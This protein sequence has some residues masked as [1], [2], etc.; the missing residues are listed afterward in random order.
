LADSVI[1]IHLVGI[2]GSQ[3]WIEPA[4]GITDSKLLRSLV[5]PDVDPDNIIYDDQLFNA[6]LVSMGCMG[7][8]YAVVLRVRGAYDLIETTVETTWSTFIAQLG[9]IAVA[10]SCRFDHTGPARRPSRSPMSTMPA[11]GMERPEQTV[12]DRHDVRDEA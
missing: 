1:A 10:H 11:C 2:G 3:Y 9:R 6:C 8:I 12:Q 4:P 5:V 7:V